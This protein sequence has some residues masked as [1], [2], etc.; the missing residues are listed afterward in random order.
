MER[1]NGEIR[2]REKTMRGLKKKDTA[3]LKGYQLYHN[4]IRDH[5]GL[6]WQNTRRSVR[7]QG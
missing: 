1:L 5:E 6:R 3:I 4:Y 7:N 2:Q